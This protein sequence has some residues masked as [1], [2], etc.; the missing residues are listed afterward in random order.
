MLKAKS[1]TEN[2]TQI[3]ID[4]NEPMQSETIYWSNDWDSTSEEPM[5]DQCLPAEDDAQFQSSHQYL[6]HSDDT[7]DAAQF[8]AMTSK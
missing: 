8:P 2:S 6:V 5:S 7:T 4:E 1:M 3:M